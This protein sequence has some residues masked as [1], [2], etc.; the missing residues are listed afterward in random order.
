MPTAACSSW[1]LKL[2]LSSNLRVKTAVLC[3][4]AGI[5]PGCCCTCPGVSTNALLLLAGNTAGAHAGAEA[6]AA[7]A[8]S[9]ELR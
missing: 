3:M 9:F 8:V 1:R 4:L 7:A 6:A 5:L 2:R